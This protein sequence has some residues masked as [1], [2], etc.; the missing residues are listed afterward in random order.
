MG[1][2]VGMHVRPTLEN[3]HSART[4]RGATTVSGVP[5]SGVRSRRTSSLALAPLRVSNRS[6]GRV[7]EGDGISLSRLV[8]RRASPRCRSSSAVGGAE[9]FSI[10]DMLPSLK[11]RLPTAHRTVPPCARP[12]APFR[13]AP[14]RRSARPA[15]WSP[16]AARRPRWG[17]KPR[18]GWGAA[19]GTR[20][21]PPTASVRRRTPR[22]RRAMGLVEFRFRR[23]FSWNAM[24]AST[25]SSAS[26]TTAA[27]SAQRGSRSSSG[28]VTASLALARSGCW[29]M[30]RTAADAKLW[31]SR[32]R[33]L[34]TLRRPVYRWGD[35]AQ[36]PGHAVQECAPARL[37]LA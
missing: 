7:C 1:A 25:S 14:G 16:A 15:A 28:R 22:S 18:R 27:A 17:G 12:F 2:A 37:H 4:P 24:V 13:F 32:G 6:K 36:L 20:S 19:A 34:S 29:K 30:P 8:R 31:A 21:G 11:V 3:G 33:R 23:R 10:S 26:H 35:G 5:G 9:P